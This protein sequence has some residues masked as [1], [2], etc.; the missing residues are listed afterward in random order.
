MGFPRMVFMVLGCTLAAAMQHPA[1]AR[2]MG[3]QQPLAPESHHLRAH[4]DSEYQTP[5]NNHVLPYR[6]ADMVAGKH[7]YEQDKNRACEEENEVVRSK[8][9]FVREATEQLQ[10][11]EDAKQSACSGVHGGPAM[12]ANLEVCKQSCKT[13]AQAARSPVAILACQNDCNRQHLRDSAVVDPASAHATSDAHDR[14]LN[15]ENAGNS[16]ACDVAANKVHEKKL[17]LTQAEG[18]LA[19]AEENNCRPKAERLSGNAHNNIEGSAVH[20]SAQYRV[21]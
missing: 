4:Q 14:V 16:R 9:T 3:T 19:A 21:H 8:K 1:P 10:H 6:D 11:A 5:G 7:P 13:D 2:I 18:E 20:T 17:Q 12:A 15:D